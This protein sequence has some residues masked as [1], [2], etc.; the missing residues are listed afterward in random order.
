MHKNSYRQQNQQTKHHNLST[1]SELRRDT[2]D[3]EDEQHDE[4]TEAEDVA[5]E[6][7]AEVVALHLLR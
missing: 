1:D 7:P 6:P 3:A 4:Q 2:P 5:K